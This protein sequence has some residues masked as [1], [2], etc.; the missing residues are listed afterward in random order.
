[1][2]K[3]VN[4]NKILEII[5]SSESSKFRNELFD[6]YN[7]SDD[8]VFLI[9][10]SFKNFFSDEIS[11]TDFLQECSHFNIKLIEEYLEFHLKLIEEYLDSDYVTLIKDFSDFIIKDNTLKDKKIKEE[12]NQ[13]LEDNFDAYKSGDIKNIL[14]E[15]VDKNKKRSGQP[16]LNS[17]ENKEETEESKTEKY[18]EEIKKIIKE[19][20]NQEFLLGAKN[21]NKELTDGV[22][23]PFDDPSLIIDEVVNVIGLRFKN[24]ENREKFYSILIKYLKNIRN[25]NQSYE[26]LIDGNIGLSVSKIAAEKI[27]NLTEKIKKKKENNL[28]EYKKNNLIEKE[29]KD[30]V[31]NILGVKIDDKDEKSEN[32]S[33]LNFSKNEKDIFHF[34]DGN[35]EELYIKREKERSQEIDMDMDIG[36]DIHRDFLSNKLIGPVEELAYLTILDF[37]SLGENLDQRID[38]LR[39]KI[40]TLEEYGFNKKILGIKAWLNSEVSEVYKAIL[41]ESIESGSIEKAILKRKEKNLLFLTE[42]EINKIAEINREFRI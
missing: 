36:G 27:L 32:N 1:M 7:I 40:N 38:K 42:D 12:N 14:E 34:Y 6:R 17:T 22:F 31:N 11:F 37:R 24:E 16:W 8:D 26:V 25:K 15:N 33:D 18:A 29:K 35:I 10:S 9:N 3:K 21:V 13:K 5:L 39:Q 19:E 2:N 23:N 4:I 41:N 28:L 20:I 30:S